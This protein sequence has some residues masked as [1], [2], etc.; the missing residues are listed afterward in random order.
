MISG[1]IEVN[2]FVQIRLILELKF[3]DGKRQWIV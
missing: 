1:E 3:G 2:Q